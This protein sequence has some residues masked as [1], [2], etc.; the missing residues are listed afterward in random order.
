M[1]GKILVPVDGSETSKRGFEEACRLAK[2]QDARLRCLHVIDE[3][4]LSANY[5]GVMYLPEVMDK[6][7][8]N[9][10]EILNEAAEQA[11]MSGVKVETV[12]RESAERRVSDVIVDEAK[13]WAADLIVMGTHGRRGL[14]HLALGSDAEAVVRNSPVPVLLVRSGV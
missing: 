4:Y 8:D 5:V 3:H 14:G 6:L 10:R 11:G 7:R 2:E 12:L 13:T 1:Y 9:G